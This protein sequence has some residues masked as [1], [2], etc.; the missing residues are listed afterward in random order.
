[1]KQ[2]Q[3]LTSASLSGTKEKKMGTVSPEHSLLLAQRAVVCVCMHT[4]SHTF[5]NI[6]TFYFYL[7]VSK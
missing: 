6:V 2:L 1:M 4:H 7:G 5:N 3:C